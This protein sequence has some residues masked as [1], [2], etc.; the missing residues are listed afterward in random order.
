MQGNG[1]PSHLSTSLPS[2]R[3]WAADKEKD[4]RKIND[5][6]SRILK[7]RLK[8]EEDLRAAQIGVFQ[9]EWDLQ[10]CD[11]KLGVSLLLF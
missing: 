5:E 4:I 7:E 2:L 1:R 9:A 3:P 11:L 6:H 10:K 8:L